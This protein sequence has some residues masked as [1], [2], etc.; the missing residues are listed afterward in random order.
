MTPEG[1]QGHPGEGQGLAHMSIFYQGMAPPT[2]TVHEI[3][4]RIRMDNS[5]KLPVGKS[6][7][8]KI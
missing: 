7:I 6:S 1:P 2:W 4:R 5:K 8:N 3:K